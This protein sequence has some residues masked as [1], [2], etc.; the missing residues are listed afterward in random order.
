METG[1]CVEIEDHGEYAFT[2]QPFSNNPA[3]FMLLLTPAYSP[4]GPTTATDDAPQQAYPS[5]LKIFRNGHLY[6]SIG[7]QLYDMV[8][9]RQ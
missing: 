4:D 9:R 2:A 7:D 8:G 6:I 3:R 1:I 5:S